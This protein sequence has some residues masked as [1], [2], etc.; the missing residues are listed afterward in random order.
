MNKLRI[1]IPILL[2]V[3]I[4][5]AGYRYLADDGEEAAAVTYLVQQTDFDIDVF[6]TGE[7]QAKNSIKVRGPKGMRSAGI[8]QTSITDLVKEGTIVKEG[9]Y[10][11]T[12]DRSEIATKLSEIQTEMDK[13][14]TQLDQAK[15][16]TAIEL[17]GIRDQLINL[18]FTKEEKQLQVEQSKFEPQM[19][20]RQAEL[21]LQKIERE[22]NQLEENLILKKKQAI[23]KVKEIA[24]LLLQNRNKFKKLSDLSEQ[25][26]VKAP[27]D[28][29]VIYQRSWQGKKGPG[30]QVSSWDPVVAELPDLTSMVSKTYVNEVDIRKIRLGQNVDISV[31]AFPDNTYTG[32]VVKIANIGEQ[33]RNSDAKVFEVMIQVNER[34]S[35]LRP[36]MTTNNNIH[37]WK[38]ENVLSIPLE[39]LHQDTNMYVVVKEANNRVRQEVITGES[40]TDAIIIAYGL[41]AGAEIYLSAV[42]DA[43]SLELRSID[44]QKRA[45]V[46]EDLNRQRKE[47]EQFLI[48]QLKKVSEEDVPQE[49]QESGGSFII[50]GG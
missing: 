42:P 16:D 13:V 23:A 38:Y 24:T 14:Q 34:D 21:D 36:A 43:A 49:Q 48:E 5:F 3:V 17:S 1:I 29:M 47:K 22:F 32:K 39:A 15:I 4:A 27:S 41:E 6:A 37:T 10:V 26:L 9:Q 12:L 40:N 35:I 25:F 18:N 28:G 31:D 8:Y 20:I 19:V 46:L 33:Y 7:L 30:S 50:I 45:E 44:A 11:A 2:I